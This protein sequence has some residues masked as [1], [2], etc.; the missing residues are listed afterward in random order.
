MKDKLTDPAIES[1]IPRHPLA[2]WGIQA[3]P[4]A[5]IIFM[6]FGVENA[7]MV[8]W[9]TLHHFPQG[10]LLNQLA[11]FGIA[12][13]TAL[14]VRA[15]GGA[16]LDALGGEA[17]WASV[18][19]EVY[20]WGRWVQLRLAAHGILIVTTVTLISIAPPFDEDGEAFNI[21]ALLTGTTAFIIEGCSLW[22]ECIR[23]LKRHRWLGGQDVV[24]WGAVVGTGVAAAVVSMMAAILVCVAILAIVA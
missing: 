20:S 22:R 15:G 18:K 2:T 4:L 24:N 9:E 16:F 6:G 17:I 19:K 7:L 1:A 8:I 13:V 21:A 23:V 12:V 3:I 11:R 14:L 5:L 10:G